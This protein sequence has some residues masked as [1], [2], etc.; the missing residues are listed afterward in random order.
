MKKV[1]RATSTHQ[2]QFGSFLLE[3]MLDTNALVWNTLCINL[4]YIN[5]YCITSNTNM[6]QSAISSGIQAISNENNKQT[7]GVQLLLFALI[8]LY[9]SPLLVYLLLFLTHGTHTLTYTTVQTKDFLFDLAQHSIA[10]YGPW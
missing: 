1:K 9:H 5:C 4:D 7:Y 6:Q 2:S 10:I 3:N 8:C